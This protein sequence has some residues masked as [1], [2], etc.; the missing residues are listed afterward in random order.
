M[1]SFHHVML[2]DH[3][4]GSMA[5]FWLIIFGLDMI[6]S[7]QDCPIAQICQV[8]WKW[9]K[10][11]GPTY[12]KQMFYIFENFKKSSWQKLRKTIL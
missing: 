1:Y 12:K 3:R 9:P 7:H 5:T 6:N 4:G 2:Q 8:S 10:I 11:I